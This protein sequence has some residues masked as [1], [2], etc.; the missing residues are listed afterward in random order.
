M[1]RIFKINKTDLIGKKINHIL[2]ESYDKKH[3]HNHK[4]LCTCVCGRT[5]S[6]FRGALISKK[7]PIQSCGC[8]ARRES[9]LRTGKLSVAY[10]HGMVHTS[11]YWRW[12]S[13][14][15]RCYNKSAKKYPRYGGRGI[16]VCPRWHKFENFFQD[17]GHPPNNLSIDRI[18]TDGDYTPENCR[19]ADQKTQQ[20][21][22]ANTR[23]ISAFGETKKI[24]EWA[25]KTGINSKIIRQR[26]DRD[27]LTAE[28]A[29]SKPVLSE[30]VKP[31]FMEKK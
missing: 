14:M 19:W 20:N 18:D 24:T 25:D 27:G 16:S 22:R 6:V 28:V 3:G 29:L 15:G 4:Y 30:I 13:M 23:Y 11:I 26:I 8:A 21:N 10:K 5:L 12:C 17:M 1:G 2:V 9:S 31:V 7:S